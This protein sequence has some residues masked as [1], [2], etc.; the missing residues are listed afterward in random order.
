MKRFLLISSF[1]FAM[2]SFAAD[3]KTIEAE[4][5]RIGS[6]VMAID[7]ALK[8]PADQSS[9]ETIA[10]FGTDSRHY[11][12]IRGWLVELLKGSESQLAA[13]QDPDLKAKHRQKV[14]FL[15]KAIR[16]IDLE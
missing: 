10:R 11:V 5:L 6:M 14:D 15:K 2:P 1:M 8:K 4:Q 3:Q 12:M 9:L 13:T 16:R 7:A